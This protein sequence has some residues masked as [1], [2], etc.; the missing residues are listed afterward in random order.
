MVDV[1]QLRSKFKQTTGRITVPSD[2][3]LDRTDRCSILWYQWL[4]NQ[5]SAPQ[6][7]MLKAGDPAGIIAD[8]WLNQ[9]RTYDISNHLSSFTFTKTM[10]Q[11]AG[12]WEILLEDSLEWDRYIRPGEWIVAMMASNDP[13]IFAP[14][15]KAR[16]SAPQADSLV[17]SAQKFVDKLAGATSQ[18]FTGNLELSD[19]PPNLPERNIQFGGLLGI[20]DKIR[21]IGV[22]TRVG[23]IS[24]VNENGTEIIQY[25]VSGKDFGIVF[26]DT[27][28]WLNFISQEKSVFST[29]LKDVLPAGVVNLSDW[30]KI[31]Y[32]T[33]LNPETLF[34]GDN[35]NKLN[36]AK[37]LIEA[38]RQWL[39]PKG[40]INDL[41]LSVMQTKY[42]GDHFG[43]LT[44]VMQ[45]ISDTPFGTGQADIYTPNMGS[46]WEKLQ[47]L[48]QPEFH[49]LF[50]EIGEDGTPKLFFRPIPFSRLENKPLYPTLASSILTLAD[51]ASEFPVSPPFHSRDGVFGVLLQIIQESLKDIQGA[52]RVL[53]RVDVHPLEI[54]TYDIGPSF[55]ERYNHFITDVATS[56]LTRSTAVATLQKHVRGLF[57]LRDSIAIRRNGFRPL[58]LQNLQMYKTALLGDFNA[59]ASQL[60]PNKKIAPDTLFLIELNHLLMDYHAGAQ[61][62]YSGTLT[63]AGKNQIR[64]GKTLVVDQTAK[65]IGNYVFYIEGYTDHFQIDENGTGTWTQTVQLTRGQKMAALGPFPSAVGLIEQLTEDLE[66]GSTFHVDPGVSS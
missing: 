40:L 5:E 26:D 28:L 9:T 6:P 32:Q 49:E 35:K 43:S 52:R 13:A 19:P 17:K 61:N 48:S 56:S 57:P 47:S 7:N 14:K 58:H 12:T 15:E 11:A 46:L 18:I 44:S 41:S 66:S 29:L 38:S 23:I 59:L 63:M 21:T 65:K 54:E 37:S 51:L 36:Q 53:H 10:D 60:P 2:N 31:W 1:R 24:S 30:I 25:K 50:T 45:E 8:S 55:E 33:F 16:Q 4:I 39:L 42:L 22:V 34:Q 20:R 62:F 27:R 3:R 64:L